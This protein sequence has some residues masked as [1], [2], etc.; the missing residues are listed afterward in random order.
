ML[1]ESSILDKD[2]Q[3]MLREVKCVAVKVSRI[4]LT[5]TAKQK[6]TAGLELH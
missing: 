6:K 4:S 3:D 5:T 1:E 2:K